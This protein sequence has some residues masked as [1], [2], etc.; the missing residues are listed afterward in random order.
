MLKFLEV[1]FKVEHNCTTTKKLYTWQV[2]IEMK[3][4]ANI[5]IKSSEIKLYSEISIF[6][7]LEKTILFQEAI[8]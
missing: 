6:R 8:I 3:I 7:I 4:L 5:V 2:L 1:L